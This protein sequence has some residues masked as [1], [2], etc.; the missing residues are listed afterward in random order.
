[1]TLLFFASAAVP[2]AAAAHDTT[3]AYASRGACEASSAEQS[4][5]ERDWVLASFPDL[6]SSPGEV[7]SFLTRAFTCDVNSSDG[8]YY[9]TDHITDVLGSD[10][11][12]Q[13]NH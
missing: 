12:Q 4:N 13:R 8:Q 2:T 6:F 7:S 10:W 9:A 3:T 11:Y 1:M 5:N